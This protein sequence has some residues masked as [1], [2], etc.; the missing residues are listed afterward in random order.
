L[1]YLQEQR[2]LSAETICAAGIGYVPADGRE[3]A[4]TWGLDDAKPVWLPRGILLPCEAQGHLWYVKVRRPAGE[5]KYI[6]PR[7]WRP[8]LYGADTLRG[9]PALILTEGE[10]DALLLRQAAGDLVDVATL[11]SA[12][13]RLS[14]RWFTRLLPAHRILVVYD[15]DAA[16]QRGA[17]TLADLSARVRVV[18]PL[19]GADL[20]E[21][22]QRG[23]DLR[24]WAQYQLA[25][26]A[27]Q[28]HT[29]VAPAGR[30]WWADAPWH[31]RISDLEFRFIIA[32]YIDY[33]GVYTPDS[34]IREPAMLDMWRVCRE[35]AT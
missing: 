33:Y 14:G 17:G 28:P 32:A 26:H 16:G 7:G 15:E 10:F 25:R 9:R 4:A 5:P 18:H 22:W 1:A 34:P 23:G 29:D 31:G 11:G 21:Q 24:A 8:A 3:S 2:G 19:G 13:Q 20:T 12:S 35:S 27:P 6:A 30:C